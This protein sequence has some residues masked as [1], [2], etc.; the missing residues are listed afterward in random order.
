MG[1]I[2]TFLFIT[3]GILSPNPFGNN[4]DVIADESYFL[5]SSLSAIEK[6]TLPGWEFSRSGNYYG[7]PQTYIDTAIL[8]PVVAAVFALEHFSVVATKVW[9]A[10]HTGDL[11]H[12]LRLVNGIVAL[13]ILTFCFWYFKRRNIPRPLVYNLTLFLFLLLSNVLFLQFLHTAKVWA[14][15]SLILAVASTFFIANEYYIATTG[16]PFLRKETYTAL[17]VWSGVLIFFQNYFGLFSV[18]LLVLYAIFLRH[19]NL[20]DISDYIKKYWYLILFFGLTQI[21]F[22]YRAVFVN[23]YRSFSDMS[24]RTVDHVDWAGRLYNP[25]VYAITGQPFVVLYAVMVLVVIALAFYKKSFFSDWRRRRLIIIACAH[26]LLVY[27]FFHVAAGMSIAPRYGILLSMTACFSL[28]LLLKEFSPRLTTLTLGMSVILFFIVNIHAIALYWRPS[29]EVTLLATLTARYNTSDTVF[30]E[31]SSALRLTL[32]VNDRSLLLLDEKRASFE[33]FQFLMQHLDLVRTAVTFK[34]LTLI[35]YNDEEEAAA[36]AKFK[37]TGN[38]VWVITTDCSRLC[39]TTE[40]VAG[41]CFEI[42]TNACGI[43]SQEPNGLS[44]FL[45]STE[46]G[47]AYIVRRAQ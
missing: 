10:L 7:G 20:R 39:S 14:F 24:T 40:V 32:P 18:F 21:S 12:V 38:S 15:Y 34:P 4:P 42:H 35:T 29:S 13:G 8:V 5:T 1:I 19:L 26:P 16:T 37:I 33:R 9:V 3:F 47:N 36:V 45:S 6:G 17:L 22:V 43:S 25:L 23:G 28:V 11:L 27:L 44:V 31:N 41:T 2:G 46:L 30:I